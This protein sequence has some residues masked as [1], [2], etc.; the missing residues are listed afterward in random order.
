[1][2]W[3]VVLGLM[4]Y[5]PS[6]WAVGDLVTKRAAFLAAVE[7]KELKLGIIRLYVDAEGQIT[8]KALGAKVRGEWSWQEGYFCRTLFWGDDDLGFNCQEV[9]LSPDGKVIT[10]TSDRGAG[11]SA[12][13]KIRKR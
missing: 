4:L 5:A 7:E 10:F 12:D 13:F 6:A 8:G 1:M 3:I 9:R 2:R 11:R